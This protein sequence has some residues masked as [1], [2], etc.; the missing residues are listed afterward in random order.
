MQGWRGGGAKGSCL[1][2]YFR[3]HHSSG[4]PS[5][6]DQGVHVW[7]VGYEQCTCINHIAIRPS[8]TLWDKHLQAVHDNEF[9]SNSVLHRVPGSKPVQTEIKTCHSM[10]GYIYECANKWHSLVLK[11]LK[12]MWIWKI[13][14]L[15]LKVRLDSEI[16][17]MVYWKQTRRKSM[18]I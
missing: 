17:C 16:C 7:M 11:S 18:P 3:A 2:E 1:P 4:L 8:S 10:D 14:K 5:I 6:I 13:S 12:P 9:H 15:S